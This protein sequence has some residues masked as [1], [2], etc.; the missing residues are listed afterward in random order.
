MVAKDTSR[1][2]DVR[3]LFG[4]E[5]EVT[6]LESIALALSPRDLPPRREILVKL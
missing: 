4:F 1:R 5:Q 3:N 2:I 6:G